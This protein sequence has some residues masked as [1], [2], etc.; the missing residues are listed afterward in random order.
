MPPK[1][2]PDSNGMEAA[3]PGNG[4]LSV[5]TRRSPLD[6]KVFRFMNRARERHATC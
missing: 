5:V 4:T 3:P 2:A 1:F 6:R